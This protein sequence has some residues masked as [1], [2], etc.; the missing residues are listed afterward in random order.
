MAE[1]GRFERQEPFDPKRA[2]ENMG[3]FMEE[4]LEDMSSALT[5][6]GAK[7]ERLTRENEKLNRRVGVLERWKV[8]AQRDIEGLKGK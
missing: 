4:K 8:V 6:T 3:N 7:I 1:I 5:R 2:I